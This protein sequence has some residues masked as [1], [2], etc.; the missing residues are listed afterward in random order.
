[1][2]SGTCGAPA[3]SAPQ[4]PTPSDQCWARMLADDAYWDVEKSIGK[5][6]TGDE[7]DY[8]VRLWLGGVPAWSQTP[9]GQAEPSLGGGQQ[10][11]QRIVETERPPDPAPLASTIADVVRLLAEIRDLMERQTRPPAELIDRDGVAAL[12]GIGT[13]TFD[14]LRKSGGIGPRP[15]T[16]AGVKFS[17]AEVRMWLLHRDRTGELFNEQ[18]WGPIWRQLQEQ[19]RHGPRR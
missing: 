4:R 10:P 8:L 19:N 2:N 5:M 6:W 17:A 11:E 15:L 1:M 13:S 16:L 12:L 7:N 14:R 9:P 18:S 3:P